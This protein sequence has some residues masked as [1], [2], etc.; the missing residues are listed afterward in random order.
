MPLMIV[1]LRSL[2]GLD[3]IDLLLRSGLG[4]GLRIPFNK[5]LR[6]DGGGLA[7]W[8][9]PDGTIDPSMP[10]WAVSEAVTLV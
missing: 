2:S 8:E 10:S 7:S 9:P 6:R 5:R 1:L 4:L 3:D